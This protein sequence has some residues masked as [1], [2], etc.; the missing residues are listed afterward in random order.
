MFCIFF[1]VVAVWPLR[2]AEPIRLWAL[3][4]AAGLCVC[5]LFAPRLLRRANRIWTLF[6]FALGKIAAP[7]AMGVLFYGVVTPTGFLLRVCGKDLLRLSRSQSQ[8]YWVERQPPGPA[9]ETMTNQF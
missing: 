2:T 7:V 9:P 5:A 4:L 3:A 8:T 6:G 1:C